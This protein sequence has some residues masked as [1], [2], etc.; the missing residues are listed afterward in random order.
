MG[1]DPNKHAQIRS[2]YKD[3]SCNLIYLKFRTRV[4]GSGDNHLINQIKI[5]EVINTN[6][7]K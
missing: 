3:Y 6:F 7:D 2:Y 1:S 5:K 4:L